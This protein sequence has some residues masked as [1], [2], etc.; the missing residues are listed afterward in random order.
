MTR[1]PTGDVSLSCVLIMTSLLHGV[2][3]F[4]MLESGMTSHGSHQ[5]LKPAQLQVK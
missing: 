1:S 5:Y 3:K 2:L 4:V